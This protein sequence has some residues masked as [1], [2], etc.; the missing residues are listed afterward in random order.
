MSSV[1]SDPLLHELMQGSAGPCTV[2]DYFQDIWK[3]T[4]WNITM[5]SNVTDSN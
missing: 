3:T 1:G 5:L 2:H 4:E